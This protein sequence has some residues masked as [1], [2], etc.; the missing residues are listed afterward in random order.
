MARPLGIERVT[1]QQ[2]ERL[3]RR[4]S[5]PVVLLADVLGCDRS[6][7]YRYIDDGLVDTTD[8]REWV[9]TASILK[10]LEEE[11]EKTY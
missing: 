1:D 8:E 7:I 4:K 2:I 3:K 10:L 5:W 6:T 9:I 11:G